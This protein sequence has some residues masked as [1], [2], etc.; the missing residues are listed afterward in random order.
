MKAS[1]FLFLH[2]FF[3]KLDNIKMLR[4]DKIIDLPTTIGESTL[5]NLKQITKKMK[6]T[7]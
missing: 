5:L 6:N 2:I 4:H 3:S 1:S 7:H